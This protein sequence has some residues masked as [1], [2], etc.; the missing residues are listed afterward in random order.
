MLFA[1]GYKTDEVKRELSVVQ[2]ESTA[3]EAITLPGALAE[4]DVLREL[5][6]AMALELREG[7]SE[8]DT[9][10]AELEAV[11]IE[12]ERLAKNDDEERTELRKLILWRRA[13]ERRPWWARILGLEPPRADDE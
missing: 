12:N 11:R 7:K 6:E 13:W 9:M 1:Q 8:R 10:R 4:L 5:V 3:I 2:L